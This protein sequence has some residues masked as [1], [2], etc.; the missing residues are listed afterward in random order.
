ME[1]QI[2]GYKSPLY[3]RRTSQYKILPFDYFDCAEMFPNFSFEDKMTL[4]GVTGGIPEYASRLDKNI[5][6]RDNLRELF[7][8]PS[9]RLFEEPSSLLKQELKAP[10]TY[11][12]IIAAIASGHS[13]LNE[14]ATAVGIETSQCS[15]MLVTL[16]SLGLV[17]KELPAVNPSPRKSIYALSDQMFRFWYRCVLPNLSR[18]SAGLGEKVC[19]EIVA[20]RL[21]AFMGN[22][23][24]EC[25]KQYMWRLL[26]IGKAPVDFSDIGR[27]WGSNR[28]EKREE[29]IDFIAW[30]GNA[31][32]FGECKWRNA[33]TDSGV[34]DEL[35]LKSE[36]LGQFEEKW[37]FLFSKSGF[38]EALTK[39][40]SQSE[41][42]RL[43]DLSSMFD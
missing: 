11:N 2:L 15:N 27:W 25:A 40:A 14:I 35:V 22:V 43:I 26:R 9:G 7:F 8:S 28:R 33:A 5:S 34:L 29:K 39:R 1:N 38:T 21:A 37:Y 12:G 3:G 31:A 17:K 23:F 4:Y 42:V 6:V 41:N 20:Q 32:I 16:I 36:C 19:D 10:Q 24:E 30:G 18:I 13:R